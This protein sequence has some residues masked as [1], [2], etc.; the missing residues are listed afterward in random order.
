MIQRA[1]IAAAVGTATFVSAALVANAG[2]L[3]VIRLGVVGGALAACALFDLVQRRIP[4]RIVIPAAVTCA[5]LTLVAG[6]P[7]ALIADLATVLLLLVVSLCWP[8]ALGM[9]D[10]KL[11]LLLVL[12]LD[13]SALRALAL[14]VGFAALAGLLRVIRDGRTAWRTS[15][16]LAPFLAA[17][18]LMAV[19]A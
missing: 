13:G 15:L 9:G 6:L 2:V 12:G 18:A 1:S 8:A 19:I 17:G 4:N 7:L 3:V 11:A 5:T 14:G 16:P 10:V